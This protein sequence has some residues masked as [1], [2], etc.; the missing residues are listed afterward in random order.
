M[1]TYDRSYGFVEK[2][3]AMANELRSVVKLT[4][5]TP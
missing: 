5:S 3:P 4:D 1:K 2:Y